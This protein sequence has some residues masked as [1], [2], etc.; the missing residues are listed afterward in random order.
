MVMFKIHPGKW[1]ATILYI[2]SS[3]GLTREVVVKPLGV[4]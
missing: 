4:I 2:P 1:S 3:S